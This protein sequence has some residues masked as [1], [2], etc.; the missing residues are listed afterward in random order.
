L[1]NLKTSL[2][3]VEPEDYAISLM[4]MSFSLN[5]W[6][7]VFAVKLVLVAVEENAKSLFLSIKSKLLSLT[8]LLTPAWK[9]TGQ[10]E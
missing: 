5:K 1:S 3:A 4:I 10:V 8:K 6:A 2:V 7:L 9:S